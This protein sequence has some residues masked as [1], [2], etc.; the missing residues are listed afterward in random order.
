MS[1][2][3][4]LLCQQFYWKTLL[5]DLLLCFETVFWHRKTEHM[6]WL[7]G[8]GP[9]LLKSRRPFLMAWGPVDTFHHT[10]QCSIFAALRLQL[11]K[12]GMW[13]NVLWGGKQRPKVHFMSTWNQIWKANLQMYHL[14]N[15]LVAFCLTNGMI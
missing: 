6:T 8:D 12:R 10:M 1:R 9:A 7:Y 11:R 15:H 14:R 4:I 3:S 5:I 13:R 2:N